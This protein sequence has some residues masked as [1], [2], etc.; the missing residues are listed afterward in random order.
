[1]QG[2]PPLQTTRGNATFSRKLQ[3]V[4]SSLPRSPLN[5]LWAALFIRKSLVMLISILSPWNFYAPSLVLCGD[6]GRLILPE[7]VASR[8]P[9][10]KEPKVPLLNVFPSELCTSLV[11]QVW[12]G[13]LQAPRSNVLLPWAWAC[14]QRAFRPYPPAT[15]SL[16]WFLLPPAS[17]F[18]PISKPANFLSRDDFLISPFSV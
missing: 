2:S 17:R 15:R 11:A 14:V 9:S 3:R 5:P 1:M 13:Q 16:Q 18:S 7:P 6:K 10:V 4:P 8:S 12:T